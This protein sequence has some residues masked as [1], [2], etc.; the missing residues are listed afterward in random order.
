MFRFAAGS[1]FRVSVIG[2]ALLAVRVPAFSAESPPTIPPPNHES[3]ICNHYLPPGTSFPAVRCEAAVAP[4]GRLLFARGAKPDIE[5][6]VR[7]DRAEAI[8]ANYTL[9][10]LDRQGTQIFEKSGSLDL[11]ARGAASVTATVDTD[12]L[13]Y[14]VYS[15]VLTV[16]T[17]GATLAERE[18]YVGV[19]SSAE[20]PRATKGDFLYG[21]DPNYGGVIAHAPRSAAPGQKAAQGQCDLLG[22]VLASG[23]DILRTAGF[24]IGPGA[25]SDDTGE[26]AILSRHG[27]QVVGMAWPPS[28]DVTGEGKSGAFSEA[29]WTSWLALAESAARSAP[30]VV[31]WEVGNEPDLGYPDIDAYTRIYEATCQ[32]IRRGNPRAVVMNGGITFFG[33]NGRPNS[34]RFLE[35]VK[36]D[37]LDA[38]AF[39][40]HGP[41]SLAEENI[42]AQ[43]R[44]T[45]QGAGMEGKP[46]IDTES[47]MFVGSRRQEDVQAATV[48]QKQAYAQAT[49]IEYLM[50][51]RLHAFRRGD[52]GYGMLRSDQEP[53]PAFLAYRTMTEHLKGL[54]F[55]SKLAT[56]RA[57]AEGY[58]FASRD[59]A[60]RACLLWANQPAFY[61]V[62][63]K[64]ADSADGARDLRFMDL[65][66]NTSP[67]TASPEGVV[68]VE[69]TE[70]PVYL[71]WDAADPAFQAA[72]S[73][74]ILDT[75][76]MAIVV[77]G[78]ESSLDLAI[79]NPSDQHLQ[80]TLAA[81]A[82]NPEQ[83]AIS[84]ARQT[85]SVPAR[86][87]LP[88]RLAVTWSPAVLH[89]QWP[90]AWR[91]FT[92]DPVPDIDLS[93]LRVEPDRLGDQPGRMVKASPGGFINLLLP[94]EAPREKRAGYIL[95]TVRAERDETVR[96][97]CNADWWME[98]RLNGALICSTMESGNEGRVLTER[99]LELPL[100]K[101]DNLVAIKVLGGKGGWSVT[102]PP[103]AA[104]PAL[105]DPCHAGDFI[106]LSLADEAGKEIARERLA[107]EPVLRV[108]RAAG[109]GA[110]PI[111]PNRPPDF[112]LESANVTNHFDKLPDSTKFWQ[113]PEDLSAEGWL[114]ADDG[115][116]Y[117]LVQVR[118]GEDRPASE[119]AQL[120][121]SD[122]LLLALAHGDAVGMYRIGRVGGKAAVVPETPGLAAGGVDAT[123]ERTPGVT[124]YRITLDRRIVGDEV[125]RLN[126]AANDDDAGYSKQFIS[127]TGGLGEAVDPALW[128]NVILAE[129][130][131]SGG[132][133]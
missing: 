26:L 3:I 109:P 50:T 130:V 79:R 125:F 48:L 128:K 33:A 70:T 36:P 129:P 7:N 87:A 76:D 41:G 23:A 112:S 100:K 11:P 116:L 75:P 61:N 118:D 20:I 131:K 25:W 82:S 49:G 1:F 104:L 37:F 47:G 22:W 102:L 43:V 44:R 117:L 121:E 18:Y 80:A 29:L 6:P 83:T 91:V 113:G 39:H 21:L 45:A 2:L 127:W 96:V 84:P 95:G 92:G 99:I 58:S 31:Y 5:L 122:S 4:G 107:I 89:Y 115:H 17:G 110:F 52:V 85:I 65:Y 8:P 53:M 14:G 74:S 132:R 93:A 103:P 81:T 57:H 46:L 67:A 13:K 88:G 24:G 54:A 64:V 51:F 126:V 9:R 34:L 71:L 108:S 56:G 69:V 35:Q 133:P 55:Q 120:T 111:L 73:R 12:G 124:S 40:A 27:L 10:F 90:E 78:R 16:Q 30:E 114:A 60:R 77:P 59:D 98:F 97:A 28:P 86:G 38:I 94:G 119:A 123:V 72:V 68:R 106:D 66:G 15:L 101:G 63:V 105:L 42:A 62:Y 32:A 19:I